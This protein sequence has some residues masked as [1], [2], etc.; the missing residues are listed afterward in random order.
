MIKVLFGNESKYY[1]SEFKLVLIVVVDLKLY[2][3]VVLGYNS[4]PSY[5]V[6]PRY[7]K[8][9]P[10]H[11]QVVAFLIVRWEGI[12]PEHLKFIPIF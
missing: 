6:T 3:L 1:S 4:I 12:V 7:F 8:T 2:E 5:W 11:I 9:C 10:I